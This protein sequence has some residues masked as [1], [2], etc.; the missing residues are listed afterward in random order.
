MRPWLESLVASILI[1]FGRNREDGMGALESK[2]PVGGKWWE[3]G[4]VFLWPV[5]VGTRVV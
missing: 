4:L 3:P 5:L 2:A 1:R